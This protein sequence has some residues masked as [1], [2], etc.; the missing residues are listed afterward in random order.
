MCFFYA[1]Y[2]YS[3]PTNTSIGYPISGLCVVFSRKRTERNERLKNLG[4][5]PAL[6]L[7]TNT[8]MGYPISG[9]CVALSRERTERNERLKKRGICPAL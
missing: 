2:N 4:K 3:F 8:S 1:D 9:L 7:P 6:P 5:C